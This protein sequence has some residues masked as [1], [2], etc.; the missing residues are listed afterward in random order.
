MTGSIQHRLSE[1]EEAIDSNMERILVTVDSVTRLETECAN[2]E[3]RSNR[4]DDQ[5]QQ[6]RA[7]VE[8]DGESS[9]GAADS[10]ETGIFLSGI[11]NLREILEMRPTTDPVNVA[12]RLM[13]EIGSYGAINRV[14]I[15]DKAV[16]KKERYKARDVIIYF[17]FCRFN[18]YSKL[19][20][21][22]LEDNGDSIEITFPSAKNDQ[23]HNGRT[24]V[25]VANDTAVNPVEIIRNYFKLC[26][27]KFGRANGDN[28]I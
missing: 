1:V 27:F 9:T 12:G 16:D 10:C 3:R 8:A 26:G 14:Y 18:C 28:P 23:Y 20:A 7:A 11:Q 19:R 17:T 2:L 4:M 25:V 5:L 22:D 15:A 6:H 21:M 24:T 13:Q